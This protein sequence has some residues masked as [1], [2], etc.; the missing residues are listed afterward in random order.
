[1]RLKR[2]ENTK[3]IIG[4]GLIY[5]CISILLPFI[6]RTV[7]IKK[8]GA[9]YLGLNSL[10][11]SIFTI[12]NLT[13][14][15]FS[16]AITFF[17]YKPIATDDNE[18]LC[19]L[20]NYIRRIYFFIGIIVF[21]AGCTMLPFL[22][23][24]IK[25]TYPENINIFTLYILYLINSAAGYFFYGYCSILLNA[26][27]N[28]E[29]IYIVNSIVL[30]LENLLQIAVLVLFGNYYVYV[31]LL[32][33][34][35]LVNN[36][37]IFIVNKKIY[38][39]IVPRGDISK[40]IE[41]EIWK[42]IRGLLLSRVC[43]VSR[44]AFDSI[45]ISMFLGLAQTAAYN[46]YYYVINA[47]SGFFLLGTSAIDAGIGNSVAMDSVENNYLLMN[48]INH[49][50]MWLSG[51]A[52]ICLCCLYQP[53]MKIWVGD[54]L[55]LPFRTMLMFCIYFYILRMGDIRSIYVVSNGLW[56]ERRY[57]ALAE[58]GM[59]IVLNYFFCKWGGIDGIIAATLLSLFLCNF[60]WGVKIIFRYYFKEQSS[61]SHYVSNAKY[62]FCTIVVGIF[63]YYLTTWGNNF[64]WTVGICIVIPNLIYLIL[65]RNTKI[66]NESMLWIIN[67]FPQLNRPIIRKLLLKKK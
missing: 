63:T 19:M 53:F 29:K 8:L 42:K 4:V 67:L 23:K 17:M 44:N 15:G 57:V 22:P 7:L 66:N 47:I 48:K 59:N 13:E 28:N 11:V 2:V 64:L 39:H 45:F 31:I 51:W 21:F 33:L 34:A 9:D 65:Y 62:G 26:Y 40:E 43:M 16:S 60:C 25:G 32:I 46:N 30:V 1:M 54:S 41:R 52:T 3:K 5:K 27:Q 58:T 14:L 20:L 50:Y 49:I 37:L 24:L 10:F 56:W 18:L 38:P 6:T 35:T 36:F 61:K 55:M 12:L